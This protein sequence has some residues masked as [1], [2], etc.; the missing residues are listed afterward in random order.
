[1]YFHVQIKQSRK[2]EKIVV[3]FWYKQ[4]QMGTDGTEIYTSKYIFKIWRNKST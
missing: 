3:F 4:D 2:Y 1:M